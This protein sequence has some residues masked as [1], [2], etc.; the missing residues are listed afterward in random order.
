[1]GAWPARPITLVVPYAPGGYTDLTAR[2]TARYLEK[3]LG[4]SV[5]VDGRPGAGGIVGT[6]VVASAAPDGYTF[7]VC[8]VGA[9]SVAP[10]AQKVGYDP[11]KDLAPVSIISTIVQAVVVKKAL[12]VTS[13]AELVAYA[14]ANPGKLN[15]GSSGAGGLTHFSV[16]LFQARTGTSMVHI[17]FKGGAPAMAAVLSGD[18]DLSFANMTDA[19]PQI[20]A[21]AVRGLAV[22]SLHRSPYFPDLPSIHET[23]SPNFIVETWNGIIAPP[24]TPEPIIQKMAEVLIKMADDPEVIAAMRKLG[25]NTVKNTPEQFR[26]QIAQEIEQWKPLI[27]EIAEK[28][29]K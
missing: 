12:P 18:I 28:E 29:K 16:E 20:E 10:F 7:C 22:T 25:G 2:L 23:V 27:K 19:L 3:A 4:K 1:Q 15:F 11:V 8:S 21:D 24:K 17:P 13:M 6:Q 9:I 14:K 5:V 26:T